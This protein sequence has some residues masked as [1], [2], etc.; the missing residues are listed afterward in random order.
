MYLVS[1]WAH[2]HI[3]SSCCFKQTKMYKGFIEKNS[4][5]SKIDR[6]ELCYVKKP[7]IN[8][9]YNSSVNC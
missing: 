1:E 9:Y 2:R 5:E 8:H 3:L 4:E 6:G 7:K